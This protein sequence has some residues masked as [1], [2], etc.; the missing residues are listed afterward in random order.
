MKFQ[1][2]D[3]LAAL[4]GSMKR[5]PYSTFLEGLRQFLVLWHDALPDLPDD[6]VEGV[7]SAVTQLAALR[8]EER[9]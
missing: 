2:N 1:T 9:S 4:I 3:E 8:R 6:D 7:I 5:V